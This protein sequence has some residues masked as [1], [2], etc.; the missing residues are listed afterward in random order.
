MNPLS[1]LYGAV[2][3]GRNLIYDTGWF[4]AHLRAPVVSVGNISVGGTG[5]T[6]FILYLG[7][8]LKQRGVRFD[9]LSR[10]YGRSIRRCASCF[11]SW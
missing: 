11:R 5:K 6:P 4:S 8:Q 9:V 2:S 7:E 10:G 3:G 1:L